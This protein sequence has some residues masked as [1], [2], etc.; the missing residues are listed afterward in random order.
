MDIN[1]SF[2]KDDYYFKSLKECI[3]HLFQIEKK[4]KGIILFG[5]LARGEAIYSEEK[6]SDID[7]I[8][9]FFDNELPEDHRKRT[10]LKIKLM[11]LKDLGIDSIWMTESEFK[12]L[13]QIKR[14]IILS[15]LDNGIILFD[16]E[17]FIKEQK[18][19]LFKEL[20]QKGVIKCKH[21]WIW[22]LKH[23]GDEIEW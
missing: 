23:L 1:L 7:L 9:V 14:D 18:I 5:S 10:N 6:V 20:K 3:D 12:E 21:Y 13:I 17:G 22:P 11:G 2:I 15:A 8:I 4:I 19:R 16:P